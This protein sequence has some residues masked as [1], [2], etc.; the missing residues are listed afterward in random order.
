MEDLFNVNAQITQN[1]T[2]TDS[3]E[4]KPNFRKSHDHVY[5]AVIRFIPFWKNP[6]TRSTVKKYTVWLQNP[7][8]QERR[9]FDD[10]RT[11]NEPSLFTQAY[12][13]LRNKGREEDSKKIS[14]RMR[15]AS[16]VQILS[17]DVESDKNLIGQ[18]KVW[19]YPEAINKLINDQITP[20]N[21]METPLNPFNLLQGRYLFVKITEKSGFNNYDQC[22]FY[23]STDDRTKAFIPIPDGQGGTKRLVINQNINTADPQIEKLML[24]WLKKG[25]DLDNYDYKPMTDADKQWALETINLIRAGVQP[26]QANAFAA[27]VFGS[28]PAAKPIIDPNSYNQKPINNAGMPQSKQFNIN[29]NAPMGGGFAAS[30]VP[31]GLSDILNGAAA[32]NPAPQQA[33]PQSAPIPQNVSQ[34]QAATPNPMGSPAPQQPNPNGSG[35]GIELSDVLGEII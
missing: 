18:L 22:K 11:V 28:Q 17:T 15:Y 1:Q 19:R 35:A 7:Q 27:P 29:Q 16:I 10:P 3:I 12:F 31:N 6:K 13:E 24:D 26:T 32:P 20:S 2:S 14:S 21:N 25:P 9:E 4:W 30:N 8:T 33:V 5:T 23:D 34:Q